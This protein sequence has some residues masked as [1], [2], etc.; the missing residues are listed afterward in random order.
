MANI[1]KASDS[2]LWEDVM[3][4]ED[5]VITVRCAVYTL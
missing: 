3:T 5:E 4:A 2:K 1:K